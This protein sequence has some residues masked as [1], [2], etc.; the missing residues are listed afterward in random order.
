MSNFY[1]SPIKRT[2]VSGRLPT[3]AQLNLGEIGINHYSGTLYIIQNTTNS[4]ANAVVVAIGSTPYAANTLATPRTIT[5]S[6]DVAGNVA[7]DGSNNVTITTTLANTGVISGTYGNFA[8]NSKGI[9]VSAQTANFTGDVSGI[10]NTANITLTLANV[11][12]AGTYNSIVSDSKGRIISGINNAYLTNNQSITLSGDASGT[13]AVSI[14]VTLANS[15]VIA[16]TYSNLTFDS[17]G[18]AISARALSNTDISNALAYIPV[19]KTGDTAANLAITGTITLGGWVV[20]TPKT[21]GAVGNGVN[22]DTAAL[23]SFFNS[24]K[25]GIIPDGVYAISSTILCNG[26]GARFEAAPGAI[27]RKIANTDA[28]II[29]TNNWELLGLRIDGNGFNGSGIGIKSSNSI[30]ERTEIYGHGGHGI[31]LDGTI[32]NCARNRVAFN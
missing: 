12:V 11:V 1:K 25:D 20:S 19:N 17:K 18:R 26:V 3:T 32:S 28:M 8:I 30:I 2:T 10:A 27:I 7:F 24:G 9:V 21:Y 14:S 29:S 13:G 5:L 23:Q 6:G 22:D 15:G 4:A 31:F 16:N